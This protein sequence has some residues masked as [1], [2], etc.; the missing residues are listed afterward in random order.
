[1]S[2]IAQGRVNL[3]KERQK[4]LEQTEKYQRQLILKQSNYGQIELSPGPSRN[5][6]ERYNQILPARDVNN[7]VNLGILSPLIS[8]KPLHSHGTEENTILIRGLFKNIFCFNANK[9]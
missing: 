5:F 8:S 1:M 6:I 7:Y 4:L 3:I 9:Y 2:Q